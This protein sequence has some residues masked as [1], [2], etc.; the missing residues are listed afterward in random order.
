MM[1]PVQNNLTNPVVRI[2]NVI[3]TIKPASLSFDIGKGEKKVSGVSVGGGASGIAVS[4]DV[5]TRVGKIKFSLFTTAENIARFRAW[6]SQANSVGN[7]I[8]LTEGNTHIVGKY[9]Q[10]VNSPDMAVGVDESFEIEFEGL[11]LETN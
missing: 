6:K 9:M 4:D 2:Q 8:S 5:S 7:T 1:S 11:P 3:V 10:V